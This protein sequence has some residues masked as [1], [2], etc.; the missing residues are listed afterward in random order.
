MYWAVPRHL[1]LSWPPW[2]APEGHTCQDSVPNLQETSLPPEYIHWTTNPR[3]IF[4]GM[5]SCEYSA[6]PKG[7]NKL[8]RILRKGYIRF[9]RKRHELL[10][11]RG[12]IHLLDKVSLAFRNQ[13]NGV[14]NATL[15]QWQTGK[16]LWPVQVWPNIITG[17]EL[18]PGISDDTPVYTVWEENHIT[19]ITFQVTI[20]FLSSGTLS[21]REERLGFS[22]K[23]VGTHTLWSAFAMELFLAR[24]Y[25]EN[26]YHW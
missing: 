19:N 10:K 23:E 14:K 26:H 18:Y 21:F 9:Y 12:C 1:Q 16:H 15:N 8:T 11:S 5:L 6:T 13:K 3:G 4:F 25:P 7:E 17:L 2:K 24:V 22:H 20:K